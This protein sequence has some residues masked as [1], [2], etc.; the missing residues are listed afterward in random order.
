MSRHL[1]KAS[2]IAFALALLA[3]AHVRAAPYVPARGDEVLERLPY[4]ADPQQ[5]ELRQLRARLAA[6][7]RDLG[8]ATSLARRYI[9]IA[10]S[11]SDP[12]YL[13]YAEAALAPWWRVPAPPPAVRL[14]RAMVLQSGHRFPEALADLNAVVRVDPRNAQGWLTRAAVQTVR[15]DYAGATA[16]C[17]RVST[18]AT[19]LVTIGCIAQVASVTGRAAAGHRLLASALRRSGEVEPGVRAWALT[20]LGETAARSG[21]AG[22]AEAHFR[23][24]LELAPRDAYLVAAYAD[25]LLDQRR[26]RDV[27]RLV[28]GQTRVD[29]LLLRQALALQQL[30]EG[31]ALD[32]AVA[33]LG[34]RFDAALQ[35]GDSVHR[36]EQARYELHLRGNRSAALALA[37]Q[38]WQVQKEPA[39]MR[40]LLEAAG[41][42]GDKAA[43]S[44]VLAWIKAHR[45]QGQELARLGRQLGGGA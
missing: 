22:A 6:A 28:D 36:R 24:A 45:V 40:I 27:V 9:A 20:L 5:Q 21:D 30:G 7:P 25:L 38:N 39:D 15:G 43:A 26:A 2:G 13:G 14:L 35:R 10:R 31:R 12:R 3:P 19:E 18:L 17:A 44:P 4:R 34:A 32:A 41:A 37:R 33:E 23:E 1:P 8:L 16:S 29:G 42:N 11:E